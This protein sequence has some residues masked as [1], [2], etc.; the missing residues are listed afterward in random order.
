MKFC[1]NVYHEILPASFKAIDVW[2]WSCINDKE[3]S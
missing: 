3:N 2:Q 1:W